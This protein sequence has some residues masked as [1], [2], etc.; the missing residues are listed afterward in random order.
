MARL[1]KTL[2]PDHGFAHREHRSKGGRTKIKVSE[3][4]N[5]SKLKPRLELDDKL[6][7][8]DKITDVVGVAEGKRYIVRKKKKK[9]LPDFRVFAKMT[10]ENCNHIF[11]LNFDPRKDKG[12]NLLSNTICPKCGQYAHF[13]NYYPVSF[14]YIYFWVAEYSFL[15]DLIKVGKAKLSDLPLL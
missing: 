15:R 13:T 7:E 6:A 10:C 8:L 3:Y 4:F 11:Q 2:V 14:V 12:G 5:E 1:C 9:V